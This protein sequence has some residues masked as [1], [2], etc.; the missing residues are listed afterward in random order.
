MGNLQVTIFLCVLVG[1][2]CIGAMPGPP[3]S[4]FR[5]VLACLYAPFMWLALEVYAFYLGVVLYNEVP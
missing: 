2:A 3:R 5:I 4:K 1:L